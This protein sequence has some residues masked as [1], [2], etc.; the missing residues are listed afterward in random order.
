MWRVTWVFA[1]TMQWLPI[2]LPSDR[3]AW[4]RDSD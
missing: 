4:G 1:L 3:I 2:E